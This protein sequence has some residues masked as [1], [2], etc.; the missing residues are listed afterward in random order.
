[1][2]TTAIFDL[3]I[4]GLGTKYNT[5]FILLDFLSPVVDLLAPGPVTQHGFIPLIFNICLFNQC[6]FSIIVGKYVEQDSSEDR[7]LWQTTKD[8]LPSPNPGCY[9][10]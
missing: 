7:G 2:C 8:L 1:M 10:T 6:A 3:H 4:C 9:T 5:L